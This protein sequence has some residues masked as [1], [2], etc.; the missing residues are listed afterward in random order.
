MIR[1]CGSHHCKGIVRN[2]FESPTDAPLLINVYHSVLTSGTQEHPFERIRRVRGRRV[3][4]KCVQVD[5][6]ALALVLSALRG[7]L[8]RRSVVFA[9]ALPRPSYQIHSPRASR[10]MVTPAKRRRGTCRPPAIGGWTMPE[11]SLA[12]SPPET[13]PAGRAGAIAVRRWRILATA[14]TI[15][16]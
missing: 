1:C 5:D 16:P 2:I 6:W 12:T 9:P 14:D 8:R 13:R 3:W 7:R 11:L 4:L 15:S 10:A